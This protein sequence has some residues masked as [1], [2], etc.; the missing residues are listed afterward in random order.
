MG[1]WL[2]STRPRSAPGARGAASGGGGRREGIMAEGAGRSLVGCYGFYGILRLWI[3]G[4]RDKT[5]KDQCVVGRGRVYPPSIIA[6]VKR[7][8]L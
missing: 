3:L 7:V 2:D 1:I 5:A 6:I 8:L 4:G